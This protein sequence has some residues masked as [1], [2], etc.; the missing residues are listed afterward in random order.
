VNGL[1]FY[2][3]AVIYTGTPLIFTF[4]YIIITVLIAY[5]IVKYTGKNI[6]QD[7]KILITLSYILTGTV[8]FFIL[9]F[10]RFGDIG[11]LPAIEDW[12][13]RYL[14]GFFPYNSPHTPSSY[15]V[16]FFLAYP[17]HLLGNA[18]VLPVFGLGIF[19]FLIFK[20]ADS[21]RGISVKLVLLVL[22]VTTW[23]EIVTRSELLFNMMLVAGV[24]FICERLL[25][26]QKL[27]SLFYALAILTGI[28][29]ATRS[30]AAYMFFIYFLYRFR[31]NI[32]NLLIFGLIAVFVFASFIIPFYLWD[33]ESFMR[34]GP[35]A[36][37]SYL[38]NLPIWFMVIILIGALYAGWAV[39]DLQEIY[40]AGGILLFTAAVVSF[41]FRVSELG[42]SESLI[43]DGYDISY[44]IFCIP[45][46][47][48]ALKDYRTDRYLGK[49]TS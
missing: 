5:L 30:V 27:N 6:L 26:P 41:L 13:N 4:F 38:S 25:N 45:L 33:P 46:L 39:S 32:G 20:Q 34:N 37:Q 17:F 42:F 14:T 24:I 10:P 48:L 18:G 3:Y 7:R 40:F 43:N 23:F 15:P 44:F 2:K 31:M 1:F 9:A 29:L 16:I 12:L 21:G 47:L 35:F 49:I 22:S 19:F 36:V 28:V 8:L 11:R